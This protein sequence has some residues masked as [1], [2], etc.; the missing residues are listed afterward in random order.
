MIRRIKSFEDFGKDLSK[1]GTVSAESLGR[2]G[3]RP[4]WLRPEKQKGG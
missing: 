4:V 2:K 1:H 3:R